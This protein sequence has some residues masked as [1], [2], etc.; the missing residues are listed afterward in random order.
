MQKAS[1]IFF[2]I[3]DKTPFEVYY[4]LPVNGTLDHQVE[5]A[6]RIMQFRLISL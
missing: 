4:N 2:R 3:G 5:H 1:S 6:A